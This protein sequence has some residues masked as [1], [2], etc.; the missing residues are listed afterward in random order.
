MSWIN[1][2]RRHLLK[3]LLAGAG[4][5]ALTHTAASRAEESLRFPGDPSDNKV[6]YQFNKDDPD[7]HRQVL[8]SVGALLREKGDDVDIVV[9]CFGA[10]IHVLAKNPEKPVEEEIH[11]R[12]SS[13]AQYGVSFHACA[14]TMEA[15]GWE[16][17]DMKEEA[18]V[19]A[20][21]AD[22]L[23]ALQQAGYAYIAW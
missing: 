17:T 8:F 6:V 16:A 14:N 21:G 15:Y 10:G 7:Y 4:A 18:E 5:G 9:S 23:M 19:V 12:I 2:K 20:S 3:G 11:E 1:L 13:L 22:D